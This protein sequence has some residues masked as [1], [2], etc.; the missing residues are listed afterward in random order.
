MSTRPTGALALMSQQHEVVHVIL[1]KPLSE[2]AIK[3]FIESY[4]EETK[5]TIERNSVKLR[6]K[7][8]SR[9][10]KKKTCQ[11]VV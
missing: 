5:K 4:K 6:P 7:I 8:E 10:G 3:E 11:T 9:K 2:T 1:N